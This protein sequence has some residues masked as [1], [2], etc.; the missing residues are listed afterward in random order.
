MTPSKVT[1]VV[2]ELL[3][4]HVRAASRLSSLYD[5]VISTHRGSSIKVIEICL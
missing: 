1:G 5:F 3:T 4:E 2:Y